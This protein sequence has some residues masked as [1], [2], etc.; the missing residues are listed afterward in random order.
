M[1]TKSA[2]R[3]KYKVHSTHRATQQMMR[4]VEV[5]QLNNNGRCMSK[6][7][8]DHYSFSHSWC[9]AIIWSS[10]PRAESKKL[11]NFINFG[12]IN[13]QSQHFLQQKKTLH[14]QLEPI[15]NSHYPS[16]F[17]SFG[18]KI[19][20]SHWRGRGR[21]RLSKTRHL[22]LLAYLKVKPELKDRVSLQITLLP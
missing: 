18:T 6:Y 17:K 14:K 8:N 3:G 1:N 11:R 15:V 22:T 12:I 2:L 7:F 19:T 9:Q 5:M 20:N 4:G 10:V 13:K 16:R 21:C